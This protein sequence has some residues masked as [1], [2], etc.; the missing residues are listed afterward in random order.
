M[1]ASH[2]TDVFIA[3]RRW[4][5]TLAIIA[6]SVLIALGGGLF[7]ALLG[8]PLALGAILG[9]IVLVLILRRIEIGYAALIAVICLLPFA[10]VPVNFGFKPTFLDLV[11]IAMF[12]V[13]LLERATGKLGGFVNTPLTLPVLAFLAMA[14]ATFIAGLANAPLN[15]TVARHFA[16]VILSILLFFLITDTVRDVQRLSLIARMLIIGGSLAALIAVILYLLP[17]Q[18][19]MELLSRLRVFNY[20]EGPGVL[21]YIRDD[22]SLPQRA[23]GTSIDPNALGGLMIMMVTLA[24]PQLFTKHPLLRRGWLIGGLVLMALALLL[25][26]SRGSLVG[27]A[28]AVGALGVVRYRKLLPIMIAAL[29][30]VL[31]LPQ[32]QGYVTHFFDGLEVLGDVQ[33]GDLSTQMR[34]GEYTDALILIQRYP[35]F[36]VGFTGTPDIDTYLKVANLYLMMASEMGLVGVISFL[37]VMAVLLGSAW[38]ARK[39]VPA[40]P[41]V[42]PIWWGFHAALFGA[43]VGG[44]FD[45]YFFNLDFHHSVTLF[46]LYVGLAMVSTRLVQASPLEADR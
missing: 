15:Q 4:M 46:W 10:A 14:L 29:A 31:I 7:V 38:R 11:L 1:Q 24:V 34:V 42:E 3:N 9:L 18:T 40:R 26:F 13:W 12:G 37:S 23:T 35:I 8:G 44:L 36:G 2:W 21:R 5:S 30:L 43:L 6:L 17:E 16:E 45:H 20:P 41:E 33:G 39:Q 32:T 27:V 28:V 19:S 25:S 22:P